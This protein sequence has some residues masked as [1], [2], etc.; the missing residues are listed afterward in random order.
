M[1]S[2]IKLFSGNAN[3][4][5]AERISAALGSPMGHASVSK[6]SDGEINVDIRENVRGRDVF[7]IQPT[8]APTNIPTHPPTSTPTNPPAHP[9][10]HGTTHDA[11][12]SGQGYVQT[13]TNQDED[14][15]R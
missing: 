8:C 4:V 13:M 1:I 5:L 15:S 7:L 14:Q 10:H 11:D 12:E 6:F 2:D 9:L 3:P